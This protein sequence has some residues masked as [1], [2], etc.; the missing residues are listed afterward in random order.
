MP[1]P[2]FFISPHLAMIVRAYCKSS[3]RIPLELLSAQHDLSWPQV[4]QELGRFGLVN[5]DG[6][7]TDFVRTLDSL[8]ESNRIEECEDLD[9][10]SS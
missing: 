3:G 5:L 4:Q 8:H 9:E 2:S 6:D 7:F 1:T 10:K